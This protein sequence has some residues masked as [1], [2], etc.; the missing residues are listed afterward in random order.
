MGISQN[1]EEYKVFLWLSEEMGLVLSTWLVL[2]VSQRRRHASAKIKLY[3]QYRD[4][5]WM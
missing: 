5:S 3:R 1:P 2:N 4:K